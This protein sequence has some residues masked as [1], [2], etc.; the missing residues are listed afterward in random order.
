MQPL[1]KRDEPALGDRLRAPA[2]ALAALEHLADEPVRLQLLEQVVD[3]EL[4]V[5]VVEPDDQ[6]DA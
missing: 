4:G 6:A 5:A 1:R 2:D 3:A